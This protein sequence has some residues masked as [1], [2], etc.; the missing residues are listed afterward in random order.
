MHILYFTHTQAH[1][2]LHKHTGTYYT[3]YFTHTPTHN[4]LHI[5]PSVG[6]TGTVTACRRQAYEC[7]CYSVVSEGPISCHLSPTSPQLPSS[8]CLMDSKM[9][10]DSNLMN[11]MLY[12]QNG[13]QYSNSLHQVSQLDSTA[14]CWRHSHFSH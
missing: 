11:L 10:V 2:A 13:R 14:R 4:L 8:P 9:R 6:K 1:T 7:A 5:L 12:L 3:V